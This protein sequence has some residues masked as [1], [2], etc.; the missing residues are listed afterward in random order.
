MRQDGL[1]FVEFSFHTV[2]AYLQFQMGV[3]ARKDV[4]QINQVETIG[5][6]TK[7]GDL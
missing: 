4:K 1:S 7:S 5:V 3:E 2:H 6:G